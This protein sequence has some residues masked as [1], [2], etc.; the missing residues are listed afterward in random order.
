VNGFGLLSANYRGERFTN[1]GNNEKESGTTLVDF[2]IGLREAGG[3]W[4]V[5][6]WCRNCTDERYLSQHFNTV[7]QPGTIN[8]YP[9]APR[10]YSLMMKGS[11]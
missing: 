11:F 5:G 6:L 3:G 2:G 4:E 7:F 1:T 9:G 10:Q 8:G